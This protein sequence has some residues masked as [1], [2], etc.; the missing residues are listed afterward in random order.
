MSQPTNV[1][2]PA[3]NE[4]VRGANKEVSP[5][6]EVPQE[7]MAAF[8]PTIRNIVFAP[9]HFAAL[10]LEPR[11]DYTNADIQEA[12]KRKVAELKHVS[13][14]HQKHRDDQLR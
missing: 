8:H 4:A 13:V 12:Y 3:H 5:S 2:V 10:G 9:D 7:D 1:N 14:E 6:V 11:T